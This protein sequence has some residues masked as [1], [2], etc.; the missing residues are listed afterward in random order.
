MPDT[1]QAAETILKLGAT[2]LGIEGQSSR[3]WIRKSFTINQQNVAD[4]LTGFPNGEWQNRL[5]RA[6]GSHWA[7]VQ[8]KRIGLRSSPIRSAAL[9]QDWVTAVKGTTNP[10]LARRLSWGQPA[11]GPNRSRLCRRHR[12]DRSAPTRRLCQCHQADSAYP[13]PH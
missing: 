8:Q 7:L 10:G 12:Q 5:V 6:W 9:R 11:R 4:V 13:L 3:A 1:T 2:C